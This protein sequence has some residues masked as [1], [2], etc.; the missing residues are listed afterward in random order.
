MA[1]HHDHRPIDLA[2]GE[3]G[4]DVEAVHLRH[5]EVEQDAAGLEV[6]QRVEE[7]DAAAIRMRPDLGGAEHEAQRAADVAIVVDHVDIMGFQR[8]VLD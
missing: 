2:L 6:R 7:I 3:R 8:I 4:H 1:G 5:P